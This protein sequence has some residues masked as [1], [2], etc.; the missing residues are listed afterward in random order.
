METL[1]GT[2]PGLSQAVCASNFA[3]S[4]VAALEQDVVNGFSGASRNGQGLLFFWP[5][6]ADGVTLDMAQ[7]PFQ[8]LAVVNRTDLHTTGNG[9]ARLIYA[10]RAQSQIPG[11]TFPITGD[12]M[13]VIFEFSLP[14]TATSPNRLAWVN[15]FFSLPNNGSK[16]CQFSCASSPDPVGCAFACNVQL[17]TDQFVLP[18]QLIDLRTNENFLAPGEGSWA[19]RQFVLSQAN[20]VNVLV[21]SVD[22]ET[23]D[24]TLNHKD[25]V[26]SFLKANEADFET[27][28][29]QLP[30]AIGSSPVLSGVAFD[31][32]DPWNFSTFGVDEPARHAFSGRACN[33]CHFFEA[34]SAQGAGISSLTIDA[35]FHV[36][37][38]RVPDATGQNLVSPFITQIEL[39]RRASFMA[40]QLV[41]GSANNCAAGVDVAL[42]HP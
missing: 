24:I 6:L 27:G 38:L 22:A 3:K 7:A 5:T 42:M 9:E 14:S 2:C 31:D 18:A 32:N 11:V 12:L 30:L 28:F 34:G 16:S 13:T 23:A 41:C 26:G 4:W 37:P 40:N 20:G 25:P 17:V 15:Q 21:S 39:P 29:I 33:G 10:V 35:L 19:W 1:A 8:L 36:T